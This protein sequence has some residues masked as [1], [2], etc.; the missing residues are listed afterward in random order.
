MGARLHVVDLDP[1]RRRSTYVATAGGGDYIITIALYDGE[2]VFTYIRG[3]NLNDF[4]DDVHKYKLL[5]TYNGKSFDLPF[6]RS[7]L[8]IPADHAHIDLRFVLASLGYRGGLKGCEKQFGLDRE[9]L[10]GVD[11]FFAVLLWWDYQRHGNDKALQTLLAYNVLDVLNLETLMVRAYNLKLAD[12]PFEKARRLSESQPAESPFV[13]DMRT[14]ERLKLGRP[15][16]RDL[17][18]RGI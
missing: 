5:V 18:D 11:G 7:Y 9:E 12:T 16:C 1:R 4:R 17:D 2:S 15:V 14:V 8:G 6:I 13:A 10:D 3:D